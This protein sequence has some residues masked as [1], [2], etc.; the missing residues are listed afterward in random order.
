MII[1]KDLDHSKRL[2]IYAVLWRD[3]RHGWS[4]MMLFSILNLIYGTGLLEEETNKKLHIN[5]K[6]YTD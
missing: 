6:I 3:L 1:Q 5:C 4:L 2:F